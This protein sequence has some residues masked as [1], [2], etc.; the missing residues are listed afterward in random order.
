MYLYICLHYS[1]PKGIVIS[2]KLWYHNIRVIHDLLT[3]VRLLLEGHAL[4]PIVGLLRG[5][6]LVMNNFITS[7][8]SIFF[9][10]IW[11]FI[12]SI[13]YIINSIIINN[14][15][16]QYIHSTPKFTWKHKC[17]KTTKKHQIPNSP[18][19]NR[20]RIQPPI[21]LRMKPKCIN[22]KP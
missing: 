19:T 11:K 14:I 22:H 12:I 5:G 9:N 4:I 20:R 13:Q 18:A 2:I 8:H 6:E 10:N 21:I 7:N 1:G 3:V 15:T 17:G 16:S